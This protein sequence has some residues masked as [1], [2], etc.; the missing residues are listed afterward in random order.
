MHWLFFEAMGTDLASL[1]ALFC[2][3]WSVLDSEHTELGTGEGAAVLTSCH[4]SSA[5]F[6]HLLPMIQN[7]RT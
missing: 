3:L 2:E 7:L 6:Y 4:F 1:C 5:V